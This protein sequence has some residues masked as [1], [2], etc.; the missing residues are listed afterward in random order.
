M[1]VLERD[2]FTDPEL[3][4]NPTPWYAALCERALWIEAGLALAIGEGRGRH[5][6]E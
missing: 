5:R 4:E 2:F 6:R 3:F 1:D